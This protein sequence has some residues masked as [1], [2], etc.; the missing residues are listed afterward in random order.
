[1]NEPDY[2]EISSTFK[3]LARKAIQE[4]VWKREHQPGEFFSCEVSPEKRGEIVSVLVKDNV[5][6]A[7]AHRSILLIA[8]PDE[9]RRRMPLKKIATQGPYLLMRGTITTTKE[10]VLIPL[11]K[12]PMRL[13]TFRRDKSAGGWEPITKWPTPFFLSP[14]SAVTVDVGE[15]EDDKADKGVERQIMFMLVKFSDA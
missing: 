15:G 2:L 7:R 5:C 10:K 13:P 8:Q 6:I 12:P 4:C 14:N 9:I 1:M 3:T 11:G